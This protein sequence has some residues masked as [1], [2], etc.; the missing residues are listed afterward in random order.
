MRVYTCCIDDLRFKCI[1]YFNSDAMSGVR[2]IDFALG[3]TVHDTDLHS[4][5]R[6][7]NLTMLMVVIKVPD[8]VPAWVRI[9]AIDNGEYS[10][11]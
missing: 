3:R 9:R 6:H 8:G 1:L 2:E 10:T 4:W 7:G 11:A 5:D